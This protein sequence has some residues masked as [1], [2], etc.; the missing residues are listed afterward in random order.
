MRV[1]LASASSAV[2]RLAL[3]KGEIIFDCTLYAG[4][5]F[6]SAFWRVQSTLVR[7]DISGEFATLFFILR[8]HS[9]L[10]WTLSQEMSL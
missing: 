3:L 4:G 1:A 5:E 8:G 2:A 9:T 6:L 7:Q 10:R